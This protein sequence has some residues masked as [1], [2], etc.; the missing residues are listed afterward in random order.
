[1]KYIKSLLVI[2]MK[3]VHISRIVSEAAPI[4]LRV[5]EVVYSIPYCKTTFSIEYIRATRQLS[6]SLPIMTGMVS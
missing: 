2:V 3:Q 6:R 5:L 1:M 4:C